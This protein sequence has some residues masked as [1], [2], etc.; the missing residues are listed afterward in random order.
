MELNTVLGQGARTVEPPRGIVTFVFTDIEGSTRLFRRLGQRYAEVLARHRELLRDAWMDHSGYEVDTEGDSFFVAFASAHDAVRACVGGQRSLEEEPWPSPLRVRMGLHTGLAFPQDGGYVALA[1]HETARVMSAAHGGQ[2]LLSQ[3]TVEALGNVD[4]PALRRLG[5]FRLRGFDA[6]ARLYQ[7]V[8]PGLQEDFPAVRAVPADGHNIVRPPTETVGRDKLIGR[9]GDVLAPRRLVTLVGP[10]GVGKTR[11][12]TEVG[13]HAALSWDDGVWMV[14]LAGVSEP[15]LVGA[16]VADAIGASAKAGGD[17]WDDVLDHFETKQAVVILDGCEHVAA[18]CRQLASSLF[19]ACEGVGVLATSREPLRAPGEVLR[20]VAPLQVPG[21]SAPGPA[22]VRDSSAG[23]LFAARGADVRP[24]FTITAQNAAVVAEICRQLDGLPLLIELAAAHLSAQS[25]AEILAGLEDRLRT[26]RSHD[27]AIPGRHR[28]VEGL[29]EWSYRLLDDAQRIALRRLSI[30]AAG[31]SMTTATAALAGDDLEAADVPELLWLL[32]DRSLVVADL[33]ANETRYRLLET[34]RTYASRLLE[35]QNESEMVAVKL[36]GVLLERLGPWR[37]SDP[38]W[39]GEV[40]L[41]LDNLRALA[42]EI[43][44]D[45]QE[46]AQQLACSLGLY[47]DARQSFREGIS[48]LTRHARD[49][50]KPT[51]TR[52][53]LLTTLGYLHLRTGD[54]DAAEQLVEAARE[55]EREHGAPA[56]DDVAVDRARGEIARRSGDLHGAVGIARA[57]LD[58]PL[59]DHGRARMYNLLGTALAALGDLQ[60]SYQACAAEL[61]LNRAIGYDAYVASAEGNLAEVAMRLGDVATAARHQRACLDLGLTLGSPAMLAFSL[62][63]AARVAGT[64]GDWA[65]AARLH[66]RGEALLNDTG[67]L[68]YDDDRRQSDELL[69]DARDALGDDMFAASVGAGGDLEITDAAEQAASVLDEAGRGSDPFVSE[70][71][72]HG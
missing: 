64:R 58:R 18:A 68:L 51:A 63:M 67:L 62:I 23:R 8:A 27:P 24:G 4:R 70:R 35:A 57:A 12:A 17:R 29:L 16:A 60:A 19:A 14:D 45:Q 20:H 50:T 69:A 47:H 11:V 9:L 41:E 34:I 2:I 49:L 52:V 26:L 53:S 36:S 72:A 55:L 33:A 43:P 7:V 32:V 66:S 25:P 6:P 5:R 31:F 13:V 15:E 28:S 59:S 38:R 30:F 10:G 1:V 71:N 40:D 56:W 22:E 44:A 48:E 54:A 39:V 46:L 21:G 3:E 65:S 42:P 61:E 37:M